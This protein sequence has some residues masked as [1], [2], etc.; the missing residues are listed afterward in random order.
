MSFIKRGDALPILHTVNPESVEE[1][2]LEKAKRAIKEVKEGLKKPAIDKAI[3][4]NKIE[5]N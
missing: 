1:E 5:S 3:P 4:G 2:K